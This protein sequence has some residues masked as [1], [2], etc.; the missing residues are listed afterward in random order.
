MTTAPFAPGDRV[1][2]EIGGRV[3]TVTECQKH[4]LGHWLVYWGD[5][6]HAYGATPAEHM[7]LAPE[8]YEEPPLFPQPGYLGLTID[9]IYGPAGRERMNEP[10]YRA[11]V[12]EWYDALARWQEKWGPGDKP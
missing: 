3:V 6:K 5:P 2:K 12:V 10:D 11:R 4:P 1:I 9:E 7:R 8:G